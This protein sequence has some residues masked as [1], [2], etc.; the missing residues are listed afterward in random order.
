MPVPVHAGV[1]WSSVVDGQAAHPRLLGDGHCAPAHHG[2]VVL[3]GHV[4][5]NKMKC[6]NG[7]NLC[8]V[9]RGKK[10]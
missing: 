10:T 6:S 5:N 1:P 9:A 3:W 8:L 4:K 7:F 2:H